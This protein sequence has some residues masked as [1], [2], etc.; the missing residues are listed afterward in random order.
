V[1]QDTSAFFTLDRGTVSTAAALIAPVDGRYRMLASAAA[2]AAIEPESILE[3]LA[4]RV[5]LT[6]ASIAGSLEGW[7]DWSRL[8]VATIRP[9]RAVLVAASIPSGEFLQRA[10]VGAGWAVRDTF[11]GPEPDLVRLGEACLDPQVDAVIV[12]GREGV[13]ADEQDA[14]RMLW[15]RAA[16]L[17]RFRDDLAVIA[18]GPF[19]D[20]PEGIPET[21]LFSLP[22][23]DPV[24]MTSES[25]LREAARQVGAHLV[26][27]GRPVPADARTTLR[28]SIASLAVLLDHRVE[29]IEVGAAA[30][31]RTLAH[32]DGE[33]RHGVVAEAGLLPRAVLDDDELAESILGWSTL[34]G[35]PAARLDALRELGLRPW[36][37]VDADGMH[38]RLAVLRAALARLAGA[39]DAPSN[40]AR[41]DDPGGDV[42]VLSGGVF[43]AIPPAAAA[44]A[45]VD[46]IR[47]PGAVAMLHDHARVLAPLGALPVEADRERLLADLMDDCLLPLGSALLTGSLGDKGKGGGAIGISTS[48]GEDQ[49]TLEPDT[50]RLVDLP[51]GIVARLEIDP[52]DGPILG[53]QGQRL[54][55]EVSGGLGGLLVD[56]REIPL[57]LPASGES[58]RSQLEA[59]EAPAWAGSER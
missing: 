59:W 48:L 27:A 30:A 11:Y 44:L 7:R 2:P 58:R 14:G 4:W 9:P 52:V 45:V 57:A 36:T 26:N 21:R 31:S 29:G 53:V 24:P 17:A 18:C 20:R 50:L 8:E 49:L 10:V 43:S 5:A 47:R 37:G 51:P 6:D 38:L 40:G 34:G 33:L 15:S 42:L 25:R 28:A 41:P 22:A 56:T 23:P 55:L 46:G 32:A 39:W 12:G 54:R 1:T 13:D 35:D 3:D 16:A 19:V